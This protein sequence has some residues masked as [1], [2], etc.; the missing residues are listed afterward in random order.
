MEDKKDMAIK[1]G[2]MGVGLN[3]YWDQFD[4]LY[5]RLSGYQDI[6][7]ENL[8]S[9]GVSVVNAGMVDSPDK[10]DE[11]SSRMNEEGIELL[12]VFVS[13]YA[14]SSTILP[15]AQN[16]KVPVILLNLQPVASIDFEAFNSLADRGVMTGEWLAHCQACSIPEFACVFNRA[17][18]KY[19][20]VS[21]FMYDPEVWI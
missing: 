1:V 7:E 14:L 3:T 4:G 12:F 9:Y 18:I 11:A 8:N 20:I 16:I 10:V 13:T 15:I 17:S 5:D 19:D 6:I 21:V 2:L